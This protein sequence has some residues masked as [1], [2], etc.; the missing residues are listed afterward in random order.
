M[1]AITFHL[2]AGK[3]EIL[4][5]PF[6][7]PIALFAWALY[8]AFY[9]YFLSP[10]RHIPGPF[11]SRVTPIPLRIATFRNKRY[12][13]AHELLK[14]YGP[15]VVLAPDQVHTN[16]DMAMKIIYDRNSPKTS[17]YKDAGRY[18]GVHMILGM[19]EHSSAVSIRSNL[20]QC[21]QNKNLSSLSDSMESHI[22][23]FV[24]LL[25][26]RAER[27]ESTL[28][29]IFWLRLL[30]LD[31]VTDILWGDKHDLLTNS[32]G[33]NSGLLTKFHQ[34]S[35]FMALRGFLSGFEFWVRTCGTKH[36]KDMRRG[37]Y[38]VDMYARRVLEK[39]EAGET[40]SHSRDA[41]EAMK[42]NWIPF[43]YG[44][45]SCP[46]QNLGMTELK[47]FLAAILRHFRCQI[48]DGMHDSQIELRDPFTATVWERAS[49]KEPWR[50]EVLLKFV[51]QTE[52][53]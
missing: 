29:G 22:N 39:W 7:T 48:P 11:W 12:E 20:L 31:T 16:D 13:Y 15:I 51:P 28:D 24:K 30:T 18:K 26:Q 17:F 4:Q 32:G 9:A 21:F 3:I 49:E 2:V 27:N 40:K 14:K 45:R 41:T 42:R 10:I 50:S 8:C 52:A 53:L 33:D 38:E 25:Y 19:I 6:L 44:S 46:G 1:A 36:Y 34:F 37:W 43:S 47:Y 5:I 35:R 23:A